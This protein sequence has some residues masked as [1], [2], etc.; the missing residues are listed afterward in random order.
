MHDKIIGT[1]VQIRKKY[2]KIIE[3]RINDSID[4]INVK[5]ENIL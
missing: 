1:A 5:D 3:M 4:A 2:Q